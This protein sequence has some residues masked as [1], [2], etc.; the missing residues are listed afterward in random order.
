[1]KKGKL[2]FNKCVSLDSLELSKG[3]KNYIILFLLCKREFV[4]INRLAQAFF[5]LED[6]HDATLSPKEMNEL[7]ELIGVLFNNKVYGIIQ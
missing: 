2:K 5:I 1:M 3:L 6:T 7:S 4:T